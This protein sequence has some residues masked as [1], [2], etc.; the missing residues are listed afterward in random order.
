MCK[1]WGLG[2]PGLRATDESCDTPADWFAQLARIENPLPELQS[3]IQA[4]AN[5][6]GYQLLGNGQIEEAIEVF[7]LTVE[8]FPNSPNSYDSLG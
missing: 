5:S 3:T 6:R 7:A 8:T 1:R 4:A 2:S